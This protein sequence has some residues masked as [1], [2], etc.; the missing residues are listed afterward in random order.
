MRLLPCSARP[1]LRVAARRLG[2]APRSL[3]RGRHGKTFSRRGGGRA[4]GAA[5]GRRSSRNRLGF[6][7]AKPLSVC[8]ETF[9]N[10]TYIYVS[11]TRRNSS[12]FYLIFVWPPFFFLQVT[13]LRDRHDF[14]TILTRATKKVLTQKE[15]MQCSHYV[16][17][18]RCPFLRR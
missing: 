9:Q 10:I 14:D 7:V 2:C 5:V 18:Y 4:S 8:T 16:P 6:R 3:R 1:G 11:N 17:G 13:Q 15:W 12:G